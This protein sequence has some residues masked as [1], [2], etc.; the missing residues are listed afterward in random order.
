M[1]RSAL[2]RFGI[3]PPKPVSLKSV[4]IAAIVFLVVSVGGYLY[5][6]HSLKRGVDGLAGAAKRILPTAPRGSH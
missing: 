2:S 5:M 1:R 3:M 4:W 6:E